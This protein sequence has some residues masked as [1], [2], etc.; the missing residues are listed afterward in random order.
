MLLKAYEHFI[1]VTNEEEI[2][3]NVQAAI[4]EYNEFLTLVQKRKLM[5][6]GHVL[7]SSYLAKTIYREH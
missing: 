6:F 4:R 7:R 5:W 1:Q 2:S 3:R